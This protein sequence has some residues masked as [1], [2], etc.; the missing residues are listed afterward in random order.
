MDASFVKP[1]V[2]DY[3]LMQSGIILQILEQ[4]EAL[5]ALRAWA[6]VQESPS[7]A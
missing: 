7:P 2:G 6:E 5:E 4:E 3:V 1:Q